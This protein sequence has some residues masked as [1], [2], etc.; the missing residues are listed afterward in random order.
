MKNTYILMLLMAFVL[1]AC[2]APDDEL[3][4]EGKVTDRIVNPICDAN[5]TGCDLNWIVTYKYEKFPKSI[6]ILVNNKIIF[7]E[8][9]DT[10]YTVA[11]NQNTNLVEIY[12][13]NYRRLAPGGKTEF[14]FTV[15]NI[16]CNDQTKFV[17]FDENNPQTYTLDNDIDPSRAFLRN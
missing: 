8:C 3:A 9:G 11:R 13:W 1:S 2:D 16:D 17:V 14:I 4:K 6:Q 15:R 5:S 12:M 10:N 7:T